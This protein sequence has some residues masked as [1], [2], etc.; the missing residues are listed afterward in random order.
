[1]VR[2]LLAAL[3]PQFLVWPAAIAAHRDAAL[4]LTGFTG[5]CRHLRSGPQLR[6]PSD[7]K[8]A[9]YVARY[10][11]F[12]K[13]LSRT[14]DSALVTFAIEVIA[15]PGC[16][17]PPTGRYRFRHSHATNMTGYMGCARLGPCPAFWELGRRSS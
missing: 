3:A 15:G 6:P 9:G 12:G 1:M 14:P 11:P 2:L 8:I 10:V 16:Y 5:A 13:I 4:L 17:R 7:R